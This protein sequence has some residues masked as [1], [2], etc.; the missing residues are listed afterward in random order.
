LVGLRPANRLLQATR[1]F[2]SYFGPLALLL[3][4]AVWAA[5]DCLFAC[6]VGWRIGRSWSLARNRHVPHRS[7][8]ERHDVL[9]ARARR[10]VTPTA[11]L[12]RIVTVLPS[13]HRLR[14]SVIVI[15][16]L[17]TLYPHFRSA[18]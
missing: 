15:A 1:A 7:L 10:R 4:V 3:M 11:T 16:Y 12:T 13:R 2:L 8:P 18:K 14:L 17:P 9:H 6:S 5:G